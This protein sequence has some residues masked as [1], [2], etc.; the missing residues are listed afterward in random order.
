MYDRVYQ[1]KYIALENMNDTSVKKLCQLD[2]RRMITLNRDNIP[3]VYDLD[4]GK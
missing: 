2:D 1:E 4:T 3:R